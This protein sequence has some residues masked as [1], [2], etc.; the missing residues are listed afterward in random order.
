MWRRVHSRGSCPCGSGKEHEQ[1]CNALPMHNR[2][3]SAV[4]WRR[5]ARQLQ[6]KL[7]V[8]ITRERFHTDFEQAFSLFSEA[9]PDG[10]PHEYDAAMNRRFMDWLIHDFRMGNGHRLIELFDMEHG[11]ELN[12]A[13]RRLLRRWKHSHRTALQIVDTPSSHGFQARDLA[14]GKLLYVAAAEHDQPFVRWSVVIGRPLSVN[15]RGCKL[16]Q[17]LAVLPANTARPLVQRLRNQVR[18]LRRHQ[19]EISWHECLRRSSHVFEEVIQRTDRAAIGPGYRTREGDSVLPS[20]AIYLCKEPVDKVAL[21]LAE[22]DRVRQ[23]APGRFYLQS[24]GDEDRRLLAEIR[25]GSSRTPRVDVLSLSLERL[26]LSKAWIDERLGSA[27]EHQFDALTHPASAL[28]PPPRKAPA[29]GAREN[30]AMARRRRQWQGETRAFYRRWANLAQ[31]TLQGNTARKT[32]NSPVGRYRVAELL[33]SLEHIEALKQRAG[34]PH[35]SLQSVR[36]AFNMSDQTYPWYPALRDGLPAWHRP[37]DAKV[38]EKVREVLIDSGRDEAFAES[39][40]WLW[41]DF[42]LLDPPTIRKISPWAAAVL[43]AVAYIEEWP[44]RGDLVQQCGASPATARQYAGRIRRA[45]QIE[46]QDPRYGVE[47]VAATLFDGEASG[48][49]AGVMIHTQGDPSGAAYYEAVEQMFSLRRR[50]EVQARTMSTI[51]SR[52]WDLFLGHV[53][54]AEHDALW[55]ECFLDWFIFDWP[56]PVE[57]GHQAIQL[58]AESARRNGEACAERL[59][60]WSGCHPVFGRVE[61][62]PKE[63]AANPHC[64]VVRLVGLVDDT[65]RFEVLW[66]TS[67]RRLSPGDVLLVRPAPVAGHWLCIGRSIH[68]GAA[69]ASVLRQRLQEEKRQVERWHGHSLSWDEFR[70]K[71]AE[72]L[73]GVAYR[74]TEETQ[75][76]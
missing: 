49:A 2:F 65:Q 52:A 34:L 28:L 56:I 73:Y 51:T 27:I 15:Q 13:S 25:F 41:H 47:V 35:S 60:A 74:L 1:C 75:L 22:A 38:A 43:L 67:D 21:C 62:G 36:D 4:A 59:A 3:G 76:N 57:G 39:A 61:A 68:F 46:T 42:N 29:Q 26:Q 63:D 44:D 64:R 66:P 17:V 18:V 20:R 31:Q 11:S 48:D 58:C 23:I 70:S 37:A 10:I 30:E 32:P 9:A 16:P 50:V 40:L 6:T 55:S 19:P 8:F 45:L 54:A 71:Y 5:L 24:E 72:R 12:E 53:P 69:S 33:Q 14:T 7:E